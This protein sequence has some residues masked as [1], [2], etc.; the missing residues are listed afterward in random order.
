M[1]PSLLFSLVGV[2]CMVG[3]LG[4]CLGFRLGEYSTWREASIGENVGFT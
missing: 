2:G 1:R 4:T 3:G